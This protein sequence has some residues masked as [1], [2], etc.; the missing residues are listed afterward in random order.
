MYKF[1][2]HKC[3]KLRLNYIRFLKHNIRHLGF[4]GEDLDSGNVCPACSQVIHK[5]H[6]IVI[7]SLNFI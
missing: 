2:P 3:C 4:I 1:V 5:Q 7:S 6:N